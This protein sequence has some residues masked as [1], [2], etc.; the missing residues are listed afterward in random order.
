MKF[1]PICDQQV[2][3]SWCKTCK[4]FV[5]PY[6][7]S[8]DMYINRTHDSHNDADCEYHNPHTNA[9]YEKTKQE[10][11]RYQQRNMSSVNSNR[12]TNNTLSRAKTNGASSTARTSSTKSSKATVIIVVLIVVFS[13]IVPVLYSTIK[14]V[15][16]FISGFFNEDEIQVDQEEKNLEKFEGYCSNLRKDLQSEDVRGKIFTLSGVSPEFVVKAPNYVEVDPENEWVLYMY[17]T[18]Q[19]KD[20]ELTCSMYHLPVSLSEITNFLTNNNDYISVDEIEPQNELTCYSDGYTASFS[21]Q[22]YYYLDTDVAFAFFDSLTGELHEFGCFLN[23]END[24]AL[25]GSIGTMYQLLSLLPEDVTMS[26]TE[27]CLNV[28]NGIDQNK[29]NAELSSTT[30]IIYSDTGIYVCL[31][32]T[33]DGSYYLSAFSSGQ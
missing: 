25:K 17:E 28:K 26:F 9:V 1:C 8:N 4:K 7:L 14:G 10:Y 12:I 2:A 11:E 22:Q 19:I 16:T 20:S 6:E 15:K 5:K 32:A 3:V 33:T 18:D 24:E 13:M 31:Y 27:F 29:D 30:E 23:T 21:T